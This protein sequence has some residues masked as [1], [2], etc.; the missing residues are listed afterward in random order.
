M[1]ALTC[2]IELFVLAHYGE[3]IEADAEVSEL[4]RD[5]FLYHWREESQHAIIDEL[6]WQR[7][8][9][10]LSSEKRKRAV[11]DLIELMGAVDGLVQM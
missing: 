5:A 2:Y 3:S 1:L 9:A 8:H 4:W 10:K 11:S 7:G 6:E